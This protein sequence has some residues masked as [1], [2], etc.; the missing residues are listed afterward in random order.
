MPNLFN[1]QLKGRTTEIEVVLAFIKLGFNIAEPFVPDRYDF[2]ADV[3]GHLFK[4]Q[5]KSSTYREDKITFA[6]K[7]THTNTQG[8]TYKNYKSDNIDFFATTYKGECYL[9][10][11]SECGVSN[12]SLRIAPTKNGRA[13]GIKFLQDYSIE[14]I[15]KPYV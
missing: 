14:N 12:C 10:P 9:V 2:I 13:E 5:V 8:T 4:I 6:T 3:N 7:N 11:V 15:L 1:T